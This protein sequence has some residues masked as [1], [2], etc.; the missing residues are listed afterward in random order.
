M[1][2]LMT[3]TNTIRNLLGMNNVTN[4]SGL[5]KS[6]C[7]LISLAKLYD[8]SNTVNL[9]ISQSSSTPST[10]P[11]STAEEINNM[12]LQNSST[13]ISHSMIDDTIVSSLSQILE[14][15]SGNN[16]SKIFSINNTGEENNLTINSLLTVLNA[17]SATVENTY[18]E[19]ASPETQQLLKEHSEVRISKNKR[20]RKTIDSSSS[21][22]NSRFLSLGTKPNSIPIKSYQKKGIRISFLK[23]LL[24]RYY[25]IL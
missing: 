10:K 1:S 13:S 9:D 8:G 11:K 19:S 21:S 25:L 20:G 2:N 24:Y 18:S 7:S 23:I 15:N 14:K 22:S 3:S 17:S 6:E 5:M 12:S 16:K 4:D